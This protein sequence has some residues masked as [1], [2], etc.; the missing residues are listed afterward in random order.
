MSKKLTNKEIEKYYFEKF[1]NEKLLPSGEISHQDKPDF[2]LKLGGV[3]KIGI[4]MTC[5]YL[6]DG[7]L[8]VSEQ[9]Q[10]KL[11]ER[12]IAEAQQEYQKRNN[13]KVELSITFNELSNVCRKKLVRE[14]VLLVERLIKE[15]KTK[16]IRRHEFEKIPEIFFMYL[17]QKEYK[18]AKWNAGKVYDGR[19][20]SRDQLI[21]IIRR[22]E[23]ASK[24]YEKCESYW[25]LVTVDPFDRA[26]DQ[27][28]QIDN[29]EKIES[30]IFEKIFVYNTSLGHILVAK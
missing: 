11:R 8:S 27:E 16:V 21:K 1:C 28:I 26:Q 10:R 29:F 22:K 9:R 15:N 3:R 25:L 14:L 5:F 18:D 24:K 7:K 17:N 20:M 4:E 12:I 30:N 19:V 13:K 23:E 2:V 6:E